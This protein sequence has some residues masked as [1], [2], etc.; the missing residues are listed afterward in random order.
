MAQNP[1]NYPTFPPDPSGLIP[2]G[3]RVGC[4]NDSCDG[5]TFTIDVDKSGV[6]EGTEGVYIQC[7][8]CGLHQIVTFTDLGATGNYS[9]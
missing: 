1:V 2:D 5:D 9:D 8:S 6:G 7:C 4:S 3:S